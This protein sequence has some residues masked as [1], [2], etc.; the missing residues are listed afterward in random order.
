MRKSALIAL[1][2]LLRRKFRLYYFVQKKNKQKNCANPQNPYCLQ[3]CKQERFHSTS[4]IT[5]STKDDFYFRSSKR[6]KF[7]LSPAIFGL[8]L[9]SSVTLV[10]STLYYS[11]I[12]F[13]SRVSLG[14]CNGVKPVLVFIYIEFRLAPYYRL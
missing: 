5:C 11:P 13:G 7:R 4:S 12:V 6:G 9:F 14:P 10:P 8:L 1:L 2:T 3:C